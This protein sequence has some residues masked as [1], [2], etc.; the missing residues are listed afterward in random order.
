MAARHGGEVTE[1]IHSPLSLRGIPLKN[2]VGEVLRNIDNHAGIAIG[3]YGHNG[4]V[5]EI[6]RRNITL[7]RIRQR[8]ADRAPAMNRSR[9][10]SG[11][12]HPVFGSYPRPSGRGP[13]W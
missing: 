11:G 10:E 4:D 5:P 8:N 2:P 1:T 9:A 7:L 12:L 6:L 13:T 3:R